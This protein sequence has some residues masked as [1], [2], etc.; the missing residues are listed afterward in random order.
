[1]YLQ[2]FHH[3][4]RIQDI[5]S[6]YSDLDAVFIDVRSVEDDLLLLSYCRNVTHFPHNKDGSLDLTQLTRKGA[7]IYDPQNEVGS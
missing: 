6:D 2:Q 5:A 3:C 4:R 7:F 1:M